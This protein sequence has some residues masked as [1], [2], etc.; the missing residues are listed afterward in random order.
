MILLH[1]YCTINNPTQ[2]LSQTII[3]LH[4]R[5]DCGNTPEALAVAQTRKVGKPEYLQILSD[6]ERNGW[7]VS[8]T[9]IEIGVLGHHHPE[10]MP[11]LTKSY[12][13]RPHT[14]WKDALSKAAAIA[15]NCSRAILL[16][17]SNRSW[18]QNRLLLTT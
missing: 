12:P 7:K 6:A 13:E 8:Y 3:I 15:I 5:A 11:S 18:P 9:T 16:A 1:I 14:K 4:V 2:L 17:Q 10:V